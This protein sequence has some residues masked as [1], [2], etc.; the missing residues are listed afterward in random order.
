VILVVAND[1]GTYTEFNPERA[2]L[3]V[4]DRYAAPGGDVLGCVNCERAIRDS[5]FFICVD[6]GQ[7]AHVWCVKVE[8]GDQRGPLEGWP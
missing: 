2:V 5:E 8:G 6:L 4:R 7:A 1:D 3:W